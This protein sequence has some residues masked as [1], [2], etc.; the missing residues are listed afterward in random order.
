MEKAELTSNY[1]TSSF[2]FERKLCL[3]PVGCKIVIAT[4][5]QDLFNHSLK[6]TDN[7][8]NMNSKGH[9]EKH[10]GLQKYYLHLLVREP[11]F[12]LKAAGGT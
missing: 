9:T 8:V 6:L 11:L 7:P 5:F 12:Q 3:S 4:F 10:P 1:L 2:P